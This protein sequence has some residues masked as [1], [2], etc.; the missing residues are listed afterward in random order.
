MVVPASFI[1]SFLLWL[2]WILIALPMLIA[3]V[4]L[5]IRQEYGP[6]AD[7]L[8]DRRNS[9]PP[10]TPVKPEVAKLQQELPAY[11]YP[12]FLQRLQQLAPELATSAQSSWTP[13]VLQPTGGVTG[14]LYSHSSGR[15]FLYYDYFSSGSETTGEPGNWRTTYGWHQTNRHGQELVLFEETTGWPKDKVEQ[16]LYQT[17]MNWAH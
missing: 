13:T 9:V 16:D 3:L 17:F 1:V 6:I 15:S 14:V 12:S 2:L 11:W 10:R 7:W 8:R 4:V 5:G